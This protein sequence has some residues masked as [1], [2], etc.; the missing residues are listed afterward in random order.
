MN[1]SEPII[2]EVGDKGIVLADGRVLL[3]W[4]L[5]RIMRELSD[6]NLLRSIHLLKSEDVDFTALAFGSSAT[7][8]KKMGAAGAEKS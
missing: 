4:E 1:V 6:A 7:S 5:S 8:F 3:Y 2:D